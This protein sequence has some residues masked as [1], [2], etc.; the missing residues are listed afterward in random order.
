[1]ADY[2]T[3]FKGLGIAT[4]IGALGL[5][6]MSG[7][8]CYNKEQEKAREEASAAA[9]LE[10]KNKQKEQSRVPSDRYLTIVNTTQPGK[11]GF[12]KSEMYSSTGTNLGYNVQFEAFDESEQNANT[13]GV[14]NNRIDNGETVYLFKI[15]ISDEK[16][17]EG[18]LARAKDGWRVKYNGKSKEI[19]PVGVTNIITGKYEDLEFEKPVGFSYEGADSKSSRL[20]SLESGLGALKSEVASGETTTARLMGELAGN[21]AN[22]AELSKTVAANKMSADEG[23]HD[24]GAAAQNEVSAYDSMES[25]H[26]HKHGNW[27]AVR[28]KYL[29]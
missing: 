28:S 1:M 14:D 24:V 27:P 10:E 25:T 2:K 19:V 22:D 21:T 5:G 29:K 20:D 26:G 3:V 15:K 7:L 8:S 9:K 18:F 11:V 13:R 23:F 12:S 16:D 4:L 6:A 17:L